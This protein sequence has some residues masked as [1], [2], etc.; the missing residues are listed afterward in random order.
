MALLVGFAYHVQNLPTFY[1]AQY[2][3]FCVFGV[4]SKFE[5]NETFLIFKVVFIS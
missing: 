1:A 3:L 4:F 5:L 2:L